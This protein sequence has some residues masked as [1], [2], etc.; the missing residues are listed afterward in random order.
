MQRPEAIRS[1]RG[2]ATR[3][4]EAPITGATP[5]TGRRAKASLADPGPHN[6]RPET[7]LRR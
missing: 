1:E 6:A 5:R 2:I 4:R 7:G 3:Y